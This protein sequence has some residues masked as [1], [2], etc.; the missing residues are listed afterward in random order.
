MMTVP[1]Y[2]LGEALMD[3]ISQDDGRLLPLMGGSP[4]NM[5]RAAAQR[6]A[7]VH[8]LNALSSDRFGDQ[9]SAQL[10]ADG[11]QVQSQRSAYPTSLAVVQLTQGQASY[12]FYR[13]GIAD[14]DYQVSEV[15]AA[16][17]GVAPGI[18]HTG[19]LMLVPPEHEK[20][21]QLLGQ[22]RAS[23]WT[24]SVD[25]NLRP[26]L[27]KDLSQY[28]RAVQAV[29]P[30]AHWLKAS[31]EDLQTLGY[32]LNR[33]DQVY[34]VAQKL[35]ALGIERLAVTLG[36]EGALLD[37][38]GNQSF[39]TVP[40]VAVLDTV[41][42]GDTFWGNCVAEWTLFA[43]NAK[44]AVSSTLRNAMAAAAINC[45]RQ[46]CQPPSWSETQAFLSRA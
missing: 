43:T 6:G 3:C 40:A 11:V 41:G 30:L 14:R 38:Q 19:S 31:E 16:L 26:K 9:L 7:Q 28:C 18:F 2:V 23:G 32:E 10:C 5:A 39:Q 45:S 1:L 44:D 34:A 37:V 21:L 17:R 8:Y 20:I 13:E 24:I 27:A 42:A 15:L 36:A 46:G 22:L 25:I 33:P 35:R 29:M 12:G 4:Y